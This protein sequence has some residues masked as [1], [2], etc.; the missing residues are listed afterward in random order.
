MASRS[1]LSHPRSA[2]CSEVGE[3]TCWH[4]LPVR[5]APWLMRAAASQPAET[6]G[7]LA[8]E[9]VLSRLMSIQGVVL[10]VRWI[11]C[12][13]FLWAPRALDCGWGVFLL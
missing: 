8:Q 6:T 13:P 3:A 1:A 5:K 9:L 12:R 4:A 7:L 10:K 11:G 2:G